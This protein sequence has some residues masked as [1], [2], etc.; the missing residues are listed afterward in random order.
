L[1]RTWSP[2]SRLE[3]WYNTSLR[4]G[5][6]VLDRLRDGVEQA[7][8]ALGGGFLSHPAN[9]ALR[10]KL[11]AGTLATQDYYRQV[12][13]VAYR[14][15]FLFVAE[16]RDLLL[17][18]AGEDEPAPKSIQ[19]ALRDVVSRCIY[20]VDINPMAVELCKI[21]LWMEALEPGRQAFRSVVGTRTGPAIGAALQTT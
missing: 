20:G 18:P 3:R 7:I 4:E 12:L 16:D 13:R 5:T 21:N 1:P 6:R 11:R 17:L 2:Q 10:D 15:L 14:L 9:T 19:H 8:E